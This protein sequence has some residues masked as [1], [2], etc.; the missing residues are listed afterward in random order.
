MHNDKRRETARAV[1]SSRRS[2]LCGAVGIGT[3][4]VLAA[5]GTTQ[6]DNPTEQQEPD[7]NEPLA[8]TSDVPTGGGIVVGTVVLVQP[9][10]GDIA[11]YDARCTHQGTIVQAPDD[12]G[13][14]VCP[15]HL[16][17]YDISGQVTQGPAEEDLAPFAIRI[18]GEDIYPADD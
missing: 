14:I 18:D 7:P 17:E 5:C 15:N 6:D 12:D 2:L 16:S 3:A 8:R 13:V 9:T 1:L 4:G 11:A 10:E